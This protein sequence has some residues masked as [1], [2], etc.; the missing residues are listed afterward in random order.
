VFSAIA[1]ALQPHLAHKL[2]LPQVVGQDDAV[3][4]PLT[5][6]ALAIQLAQPLQEDGP[7]LQQAT[8]HTPQQQQAAR[9]Q[10]AEDQVSARL[11]VEWGANHAGELELSGPCI[12]EQGQQQL[13]FSTDKVTPE[14]GSGALAGLG[15][16]STAVHTCAT[17]EL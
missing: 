7:V 9:Q 2:H 4:G 8:Q 14:M 1:A 5:L 16:Q 3:T 17:A 13:S 6:H 15:M 12:G 10:Q 11:R